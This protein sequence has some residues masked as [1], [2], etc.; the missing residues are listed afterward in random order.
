MHQHDDT[1]DSMYKDRPHLHNQ[2]DTMS[3]SEE[4]RT[5]HVTSTTLDNATIRNTSKRGSSLQHEAW[6]KEP[7]ESRPDKMPSATQDASPNPGT[8]YPPA[9]SSYP[10][11]TRKYHKLHQQLMQDTHFFLKG[12]LMTGGDNIW[13]LIG[14]IV[15]VLGL[16]GLW[17]GTTGV[18]IWRDGLGGGGAGKGGKAAV[19]IF[20]YLLGV[21]FGAMM[22]T[23]FRDPGEPCFELRCPVL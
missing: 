19:I 7:V 4:R 14:S 23:A 3:E 8:T 17:L 15:L 13:P 18:W 22:A 10:P 20:G 9:S 6:V 5:S 21:C 12:H 2:A 1:I 16:G 11:K